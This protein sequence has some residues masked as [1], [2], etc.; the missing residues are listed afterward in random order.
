MPPSICSTTRPEYVEVYLAAAKLG[1]TVI[2]LN[3][4][5]HPDELL[6]CVELGRP[7]VMLSSASLAPVAERLI[8]RA[9]VKTVG[10]VG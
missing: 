1:V 2:A 10:L 9:T 3:T 8:Q 6:H 5:L 7:R 4:R